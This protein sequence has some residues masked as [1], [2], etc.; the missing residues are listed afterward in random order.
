MVLYVNSLPPPKI[1]N[2]LLLGGVPSS[3]HGAIHLTRNGTFFQLWR[4]ALPHIAFFVVHVSH[5]RIVL[6][7]EMGLGPARITRMGQRPD[8]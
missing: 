8:G 6:L 1:S 2:A 3:L 7:R 4:Q 5:S